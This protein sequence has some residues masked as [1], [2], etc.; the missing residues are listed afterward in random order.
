MRSFAL[1]IIGALFWA[2]LMGILSESVPPEYRLSVR[3]AGVFGGL[4]LG[5]Y[6][7]KFEDWLISRQFD[8]WTESPEMTA[9]KREETH[10]Q[11]SRSAT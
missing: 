5:W 2:T 9:E 3:I 4:V 1:M 8:K 7:A 11:A 6:F 10:E